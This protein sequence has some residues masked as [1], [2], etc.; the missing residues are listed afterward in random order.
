MVD[1]DPS[2]A[3]SLRLLLKIDGHEV[4]VAGDGETALAKHKVGNHDLVIADFVMPRMDGLEL[5]RLIKA[6]VPRQPILLVT[7]HFETV[8]N[9]E[10]ARLHHVD[11]LL[12]KPFSAQQ[13][14]EAI[15]AV[16]TH[17]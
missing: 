14:R 9:R 12:A 3:D 11:A 17:G 5:A 15:R 13:L 1:D 16:F 8:F 4:E 7:A 2:V 6:R 10:K